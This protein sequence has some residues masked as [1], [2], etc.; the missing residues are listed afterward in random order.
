MSSPTT[1]TIKRLFA[2]SGNRCAFPGCSL[3]L[4]DPDSGT[5]LGEICHIAA[6]SPEGPRYD[7]DQTEQE[8]HGFENLILLCPAHHKIVDGSPDE[9]TVERLRQIK[10]EHEAQQIGGVE[11]TDN[12][13]HLMA[14]QLEIQGSVSGM[15]AIGS[16]IVQIGG[17]HFHTH[18]SPTGIPL[19]RPPRVPHF[20][21]REHELAQLLDGLWPGS[22]VT[23]CGPGGIGKTALAAEAVWTLAPENEPPERFPDG[24]LFHSF[25]GRPDPALALEHIATSFGVEPRPSP[26][27]AAL[28]VLAGKQA[29]LIL[30]G[31]EDADDLGAVLSVRGDCGVLVTSRARKDALTERQDVEPLE[32]GDA[33]ELLRKWGGERAADDRA[34]ARI[35]ELAGYLPLAVRLAGRYLDETGETAGEYVAWLE[36]TPLEALDHGERRMESVEVLLRKSLAQVS[37]GACAVL[38]VVGLLAL[39]PFGR[40]PIAAALDVAPNRLRKPLGELVSYG[41]LSRNEEWYE[42]SHAL[43]HT[44]ARERVQPEDEVV[45]RLAA[46]Y[47]A[48]AET[49][50]EK[51]L[52]GYRR[53]DT[54]RGHLMRVLGMS[55]ERGRWEAVRSLVWAVED[56]LDICGYWTDLVTAIEKGLAAA[57]NLND[58]RDEGAHLGNLGN[59]YSALGQVEKAIEYYE[60]ALAIA[61][62]IGHRQGEGNHLGNLGN[63]YSAL[64]QVEKAIEY[65]EQALAIDREIGYRQGEGADLGNL[66]N[67]YSALGQVEKAIEYYEQ[68]LAIDREIGYR[69]GEGADLGNLGNA[70]RDLGQVEKAIEYYEQALAIAREIGHRQGEGAHL[71][72]LGNA[73]R[74]LGQVEKAIEYYEQALAIAREIGHRQ[75]E[76]NHLGNLGNAYRA[77]GQVE[78]AKQ[79]LEQ[80]LDIFEEIKSPNA[81]L[82]RRWLAEL[83]GEDKQ[84]QR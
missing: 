13:A 22:V 17:I 77:L 75:G 8:R 73:Y 55:A 3:Q 20:T 33:V 51:G 32:A 31:A 84:P 69:Q 10:A 7:P 54:E 35:C 38:G 58:L 29:L 71:G 63:A 79:L 70:Y 1:A 23:L 65:Y 41:L 12:A 60:Q 42:V 21:D 47:V 44:Y 59:A 64:G 83:E 37:E 45:T 76:G 61:R 16:H 56:Y 66:G 49:E 68:A 57:R 39:A 14:V 80:S 72:N 11:L 48:L 24:V 36:E 62:E 4:V 6:R 78:K 82:A 25:Y 40:E 46:Y 30:D 19:Q 34:A 5:V 18:T 15:V 9:Y 2:V 67:A 52:P 26:V 53:L 43:V 28:Q 27:T 81:N 50:S 74:A